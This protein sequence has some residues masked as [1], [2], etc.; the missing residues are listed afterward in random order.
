MPNSNLANADTGASGT[1]IALRDIKCISNVIPCSP[2]NQV[3]VQVA[4]GQKILSSHMGELQVPGGATLKAYIFPGIS[5]SLLSISQLVDMGFKVIYSK[6]KAS[7][8]KGGREIFTGPRDPI[9]RLWMVDLAAFAAPTSTALP[10]AH[11]VVSAAAPP[12]L[13]APAVRLQSK[14]EFV[15]YWHACLGFPPKATFVLA[16]KDFLT[17]P[18]LSAEDV[19]KYLPN[20]VNT[21]LGHLDATRQNIQST[22]PK[23]RIKPDTSRPVI[24]M[25]EK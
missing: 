1:Y 2:A 3:P 21:A 17:V 25:A 8:R 11:T 10:V 20:S 19:K 5:G 14:E 12:G 16:L 4:N 23:G 18:G 24:W 22:R 7:F 9:S 13:A 15:K 6:N